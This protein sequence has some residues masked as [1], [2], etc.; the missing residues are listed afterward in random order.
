MIIIMVPVHS[1]MEYFVPIPTINIL[2]VQI[3]VLIKLFLC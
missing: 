1:L 3:K 2:S